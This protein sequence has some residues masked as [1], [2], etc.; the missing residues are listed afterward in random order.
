MPY[1]DFEDIAGRITVRTIV[2]LTDDEKLALGLDFTKAPAPLIVD[3]VA[4]NSEIDTRVS[5]AIADA[6]TTVNTYV[7]KQAQTPVRINTGSASTPANTPQTIRQISIQLSIFNLYARR[8]GEFELPEFV[9]M[10]RKESIHQLE[11]I[12]R[13]NIDI[14][15]QP[16]PADSDVVLSSVG[17]ADAVFTASKLED[18]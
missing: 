5:Q 11:G 13:G 1:C 8:R 3:A 15:D 9:V 14:G 16:Q 12:N 17:Q 4:A 18:F 7:R 6:D 2:E 10:G